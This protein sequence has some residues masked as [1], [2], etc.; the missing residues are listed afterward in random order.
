MAQL[1]FVRCDAHL[2]EHDNEFKQAKACPTFSDKKA[3]PPEPLARPY[4]FAVLCVE[5][6]KAIHG[7]MQIA[8]RPGI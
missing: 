1:G 7:C 8:S 2:P 3:S 4:R 6:P 5:K